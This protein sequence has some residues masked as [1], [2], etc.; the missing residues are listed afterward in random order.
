KPMV[1]TTVDSPIGLLRKHAATQPECEV[2]QHGQIVAHPALQNNAGQW[3]AGRLYSP[4][5]ISAENLKSVNPE[6]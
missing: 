4:S 3:R 2:S 6:Q 1:D 5:E